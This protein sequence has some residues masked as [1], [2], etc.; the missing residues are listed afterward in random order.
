M[1]PPLGRSLSENLDTFTDC[2]PQCRFPWVCQDKTIMNATAGLYRVVKLRQ[3]VY[4][5]HMVY[6][7]ATD[8]LFVPSA[9][10]RHLV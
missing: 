3:Y 2:R 1:A 7:F 5:K 9:P 10:G 8:M 4:A 6:G